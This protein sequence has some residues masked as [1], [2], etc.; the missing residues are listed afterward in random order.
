MAGDG[1]QGLVRP[2]FEFEA[3]LEDR[4][5]VRDAAVFPNQPSAG[6]GTVVGTDASEDNAA[7]VQPLADR[8]KPGDGFRFQSSVCEFLN[9]VSQPVLKVDAAE[10]RRFGAEQLPPLL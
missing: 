5:D 7:A 8:L 9:A 6:D 10:C 1:G 3:V 4:Y 2:A